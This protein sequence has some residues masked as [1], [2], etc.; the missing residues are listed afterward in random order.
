MSMI[1]QTTCVEIA[2]FEK[3]RLT[4]MDLLMISLPGFNICTTTTRET[5]LLPEVVHCRKCGIPGA[6]QL[7]TTDEEIEY[8]FPAWIQYLHHYY[9]GN[10]ST[11]R[12][13]SLSQMW[14]SR[15]ETTFH[16]G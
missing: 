5:I 1:K 10:N 12:G 13:S 6:R 3:A 14:N 2:S 16:Y 9:T 11:S 4:K 15:G 7:F 8:I